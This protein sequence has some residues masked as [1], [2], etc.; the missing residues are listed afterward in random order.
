M[1]GCDLILFH[2]HDFFGIQL[3]LQGRPILRAAVPNGEEEQS[4][5]VEIPHTKV[6][7]IP[8]EVIGNDLL[9][10]WPF[11]TPI[12]RGP[13]GKGREVKPATANELIGRTHNSVNF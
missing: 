10:L 9:H 6:G 1:V 7:N 12:T 2:D 4:E 11:P 5:F 13:I 3:A 8:A